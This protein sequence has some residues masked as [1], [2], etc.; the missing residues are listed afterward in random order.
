[1]R[2]VT[3]RIHEPITE[4]H[5][6]IIKDSALDEL[7]RFYNSVGTPPGKYRVYEDKLIGICICQGGA[8]HYLDNLDLN[9]FDHTAYVTQQEIK[10]LNK[11]AEGVIV[12]SEGVVKNGIKDL[13]V[14]F[15]FR[16]DAQVPIPHKR[17]L[18]KTIALE[19]PGIGLVDIDFLKKMIKDETIQKAKNNTPSAIILS[20]LHNEET[21]TAR[22]LSKK[23]VVMLY[24]DVLFG[25][26][27][28][29]VK[30][31]VSDTE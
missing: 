3:K 4:G 25:E 23:S 9:D 18:C 29:K 6:E 14:W 2:V 17:N 31:V 21:S 19:L 1:M 11:K 16:P 28:W 26:P 10:N 22:E 12:T 8:Q 15:F 5:L 7:Y 24:P 20:Y 27:I 30:R 13:D